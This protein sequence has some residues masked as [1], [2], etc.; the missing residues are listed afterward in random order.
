MLPS[1]ALCIGYPREPPPPQE[2][3]TVQGGPFCP[4]LWRHDP[5]RC[6]VIKRARGG[7][8]RRG[9]ASLAFG[10]PRVAVATYLGSRPAAATAWALSLGSRSSARSPGPGGRGMGQGHG[11]RRLS[12]R[13]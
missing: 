13:P 2:D 5:P 12:A 11:V 9:R 7:A 1:W 3:G 8:R 6:E 10:L 4:A